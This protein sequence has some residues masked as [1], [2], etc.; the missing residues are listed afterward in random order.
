M[1]AH[2]APIIREFGAEIIGFPL[3]VGG[4]VASRDM[5]DLSSADRA[6][7][8]ELRHL[9]AQSRLNGSSSPDRSFALAMADRDASAAKLGEA[10]FHTLRGGAQRPLR[11]YCTLCQ[12][13]SDDE[14]WL[15]RLVRATQAQDVSNIAALISFKIDQKWR[16][17]I[18]TLV[19]RFAE[20]CD[21]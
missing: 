13:T 11:F 5:G 15:L 1:F 10:L 8:L 14:M 17:R 3:Q 18:W 2:K 12:Q 6:C 7:I 16:R 9:L 20:K 21:T 4:P 19:Q